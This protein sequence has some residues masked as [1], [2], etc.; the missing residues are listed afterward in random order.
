MEPVE[1]NVVDTVAVMWVTVVSYFQNK[2]ERC[3]RKSYFGIGSQVLAIS[4][5]DPCQQLHCRH[6]PGC[7][8]GVG[9]GVVGGAPCKAW[10]RI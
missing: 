1:S 9:Q 6:L 10:G 8:G 4:S 3:A 7:G 2:I 5:E